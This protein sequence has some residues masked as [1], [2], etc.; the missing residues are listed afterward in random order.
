MLWWVQF[1]NTNLIVRIPQH[2]HSNGHRLIGEKHNVTVLTQKK[3]KLKAST[4]RMYESEL[5]FMLR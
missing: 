4:N 2:N 3:F 5:N 1:K